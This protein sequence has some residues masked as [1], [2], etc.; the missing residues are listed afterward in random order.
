MQELHDCRLVQIKF[1]IEGNDL[2][3]RSPSGLNNV[4]TQRLRIM[5]VFYFGK[6]YVTLSSAKVFFHV[7]L[8]KFNFRSG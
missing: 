8:N 1:I 3:I 2:P 6:K 5:S 4:L 7:V